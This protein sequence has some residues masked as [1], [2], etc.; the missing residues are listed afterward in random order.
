MPTTPWKNYSDAVSD[1]EYLAVLTY[2]SLKKYRTIPRFL[3][4]TNRI[5]KQLDE[6]EGILG[7]TLRAHIWTRNFWTIS[8]WEDEAHLR[9]FAF[10]GFHR[11]VM[12]V[13]RDDM[14]GFKNIRWSIQGS[15]VPPSWSDA[16]SRC[17]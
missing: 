9:Q 5:Q 12:S 13:L 14:A 11:G 17:K 1:K 16:L 4:Y 3:G 7:Y 15:E 8:V 2:L 10:S 6:A